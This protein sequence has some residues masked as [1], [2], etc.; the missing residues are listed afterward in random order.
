MRA[1]PLEH[2]I[3]RPPGDRIGLHRGAIADLAQLIGEILEVRRAP[4]R[5]NIEKGHGTIEVEGV[6]FSDMTPFKGPDGEP[7]RLVDSVFSTIPGS[8]AYVAKASSY[9]GLIAGQLLFTVA[10]RDALLAR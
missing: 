2:E 3:M 10:Q 8:P 7:T 9:L 4:I 6:V 1:Q 5:Y